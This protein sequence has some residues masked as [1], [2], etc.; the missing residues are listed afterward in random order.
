MRSNKNEQNHNIQKWIYFGILKKPEESLTAR[1]KWPQIERVSGLHLDS[2]C[3]FFMC[4]VFFLHRTLTIVDLY[5]A[6]LIINIQNSFT[7]IENMSH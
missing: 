5:A 7:N 6:I 2:M 3:L 1:K 4:L